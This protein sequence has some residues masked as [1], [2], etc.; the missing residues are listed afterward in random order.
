MIFKK[1]KKLGG[2]PLCSYFCHVFRPTS[3]VKTVHAFTCLCFPT[4]PWPVK[5]GE[6]ILS[7]LVN[8]Q[9]QGFSPTGNNKLVAASFEVAKVKQ[10]AHR[11][12]VARQHQGVD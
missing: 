5:G 8:T 3:P 9:Q 11:K 6:L 7:L 1:N 4:L 12:K 10:L 2:L